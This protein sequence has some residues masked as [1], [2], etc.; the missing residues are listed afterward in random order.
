MKRINS[1]W[2][3]VILLVCTLVSCQ[4]EQKPAVERECDFSIENPTGI[5]QVTYS[6]IKVTLK[7][8]QHNKKIEWAPTSTT[9]KQK[10]LEGSYQV[11]LTATITYH[12]DRYGKVRTGI[13]SE[14]MIMVAAGKT[15]FKLVPTYTEAKSS[16][17]VIEEIFGSPSIDPA[18]GKTYK[19]SEQYIKITNNSDMT[20]YADSLG[21]LQSNNLTNMKRDYKKPIFDR[22]LPIG[23]LSMIPGDGK[24]YPV[25]PGQSLII[26]NDAQD[27][28]KVFPGAINLLK[29][30]FEIFDES[31]NPRFQDVD[32]QEV[33][34]LISYYK[35]SLTVSSFHQR[36]CTTIA[37]V[38]I[39]ISQEEYAKDY[40]WEGIYTF[41]FKDFV[42]E[43]TD[44]CYQV[45]N[46]WIIDAVNLGIN[47]Q[48]E[49][50]FLEKSYDNGF[51]GWNDSF[52]DKTGHGTSVRRKIDRKVGERIYLKDT[53]NST[54]DFDRKVI[55]S[56]KMSK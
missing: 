29:A 24:T 50:L 40:A 52:N 9:F 34:N 56:L 1:V 41:T 7:D 39:P 12:S 38:R 48:V 8:N 32:N 21:I 25:E 47:D 42:K 33:T 27:H 43:M 30:D 5:K 18:T 17:F 6:D 26:A 44:K 3:L 22:A 20:L 55:P 10:L 51:T 16:G 53:N 28:S 15:S 35:S 19:Y 13:T 49:W 54:N 2:M 46:K 45:P 31:S 4:P 23:F 36:G 11:T 14:Q 37:L